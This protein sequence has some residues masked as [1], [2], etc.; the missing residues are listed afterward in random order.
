M[1]PIM[2]IGSE[3]SFESKSNPKLLILTETGHKSAIMSWKVFCL[4][5]KIITFRP[6]NYLNSS[7]SSAINHEN[8]FTKEFLVQITS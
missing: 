2:E 6:K 1:Q 7:N 3:R 5:H 4:D 8:G